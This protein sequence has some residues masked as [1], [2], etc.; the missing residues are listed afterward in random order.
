M[1]T[2]AGAAA[3]KVL[4]ARACCS[5]V[6]WHVGSRPPAAPREPQL[7]ECFIFDFCQWTAEASRPRGERIALYACRAIPGW[8]GRV[9]SKRAGAR[10]AQEL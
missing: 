2:R 6:R 10:L 9:R 7:R 5:A 8:T 3:D 1:A 4:L